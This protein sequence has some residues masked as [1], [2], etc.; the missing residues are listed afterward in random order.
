MIYAMA[1]PQGCKAKYDAMLK[2]IEF[3][4]SDLLFVLGDILDGGDGGIS[5]LFDMMLRENVF[6]I[7]GTHDF[8]AY[9]ILSSILKETRQNDSAPLSEELAERCRRWMESGGEAT[10]MEFAKLQEDEKDALLEYLEEFSL[11]E[12]VEADGKEFI[13][14]HSVPTDFCRGDELEEYDAEDILSGEPDFS[15]QYFEG[16][17]LVTSHT[18]SGDSVK[19]KNGSV[20]IN[21]GAYENDRLAAYCLDTD[22]EFY[23]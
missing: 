22:E 4:K 19:R 2:E 16:K 3:S 1:S 23:V 12:E 8:V 10:M 7:M 11:W 17:T 21:C 15:I 18:P 14:A 6:P 20:L 13:L 9:E 5:I